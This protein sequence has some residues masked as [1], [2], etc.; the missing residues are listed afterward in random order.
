MLFH[1]RVKLFG[2]QQAG[3][4]G[5]NRRRRINDDRVESLR[6]PLEKTTTVVRYD[7]SQRRSQDF[8][9]ARMKIRKQFRNAGDQVDHR[10]PSAFASCERVGLRIRGISLRFLSQPPSNPASLTSTPVPVL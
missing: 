9:S 4:R 5:G 1:Q 3:A 6:S 2:V 8:R 7:M 10:G